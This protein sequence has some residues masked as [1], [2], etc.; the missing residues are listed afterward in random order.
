MNWPSGVV[1]SSV[2]VVFGSV[3]QDAPVLALRD[4]ALEA[5]RVVGGGVS[6]PEGVGDAVVGR[7]VHE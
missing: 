7:H 4:E 3:T 5:E 6:V 1:V 2:A